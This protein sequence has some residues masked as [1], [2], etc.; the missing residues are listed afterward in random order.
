MLCEQVKILIN[1]PG[2]C[3]F[4]LW[5]FGDPFDEQAKVLEDFRIHRFDVQDLQ[6]IHAFFVFLGRVKCASNGS[7]LHRE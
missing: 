6:E 1:L 5:A 7:L 2:M 3:D 4:D